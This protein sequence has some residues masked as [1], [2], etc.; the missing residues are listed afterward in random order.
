MKQRDK[1]KKRI[2]ADCRQAMTPALL[3]YAFSA[4]LGGIISVYTASVLGEFADAVFLLD[5]SY[6]LLHFQKLVCCL[7]GSIFAVPLI[8]MLGEVVM[9]INCL[10]HDRL[11]Y[12]RFLDK[13]YEEVIKIDEGEAEYRLEID[14]IDLRC[15]WI[16]VRE[17]A[18][19]VSVMFIFLL[20]QALPVSPGFL[21]IV[22]LISMV[23]LLVPMAVRKLQAKYELDKKQYDTDVRNLETGIT[24]KP[25]LV[26]VL[27]LTEGMISKLDRRFEEY[28]NNILIK[29]AVCTVFSDAVL[30][31]LDTFCMLV[32]LFIG[33][34]LTAKG[35]VTPGTVAA[36]MGY[37][38][39]INDMIAKC[40][41]ILRKIP[42]LDATAERMKVL[43]DGAE[44]KTG[45]EL[46]P[47]CRITANNLSLSFGDKSI[48]I[49]KTFTIHT[50]EKTVILGE[51]G[52]GKSTFL[53]LLCGLYQ[54]YQGSLRM[55]EHELSEIQIDSLR[56]Q[57]AY[58][59]QEPYLFEG[60][61]REN[62]HMGNLTASDEAVDEVM[63]RLGISAL[64]DRQ[65][66]LGQKELSGGEKQKISIARA[67][68]KNA[69]ILLMDEPDNNLDSQTL[70]WLKS[71]ISQNDRT[72][73]YVSH[74]ETLSELANQKICF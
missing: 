36:M 23:K 38:S 9:F 37:F 19:S 20:Y 62:I 54:N 68:L 48:F 43:Y 55:N 56:R 63:E 13:K 66:T 6:G 74:D 69:E 14:P 12:A 16:M 53:K 24:G 64:A 11:V 18:F 34:V 57:F 22:F 67:L 33:A 47:V 49:N 4:G 17:R 58:A 10:R 21:L 51:N 65:I 39:V 41:F 5:L 42:I 46:N 26:K 71:F 61:V 28:F 29:S 44:E 8:S 50:G 27:G 35:Q 73:L 40:D 25:H 31:F 3:L 1:L 7:V 52:S 30:K 60:T 32:I 45:N 2:Y 59:Q 15:Y 72:I 70:E